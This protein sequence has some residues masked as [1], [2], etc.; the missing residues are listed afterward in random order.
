LIGQVAEVLHAGLVA[1]ADPGALEVSGRTVSPQ[2]RGRDFNHLSRRR[3][4]QGVSEPA[5]DEFRDQAVLCA[6][7]G[8]RR[9]TVEAAVAKPLDP[10][11]LSV[12][13]HKGVG[14][15]EAALLRSAAIRD[16]EQSRVSLSVELGKPV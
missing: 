6:G 13:A 16:R 1:D 7:I 15:G 4:T 5:S 8:W 9:A 3:G 2:D 11:S 12:L 10:V 14:I